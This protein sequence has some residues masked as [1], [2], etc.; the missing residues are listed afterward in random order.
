M[1][2]RR[3]HFYTAVH[4]RLKIVRMC[5]GGSTHVGTPLLPGPKQPW[6]TCGRAG[7]PLLS[8]QLHLAPLTNPCFFSA[9][10]KYCRLC[11]HLVTTLFTHFCWMLIVG[12]TKE[13]FVKNFCEHDCVIRLLHMQAKVPVEL[14]CTQSQNVCTQFEQLGP[15]LIVRCCT[16]PL[17]YPN[18]IT[19][20]ILFGD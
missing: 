2:T 15:T 4:T 16:L 8:P 3:A 19:E 14:I 9:F 12:G 17:C 1:C 5:R 18:D 13:D 10:T 11:M 20:I 7:Q 6:E